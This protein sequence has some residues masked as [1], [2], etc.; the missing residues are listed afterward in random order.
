MYTACKIPS[1][2][3]STRTL[4]TL[5]KSDISYIGVDAS[6]SSSDE[7]LDEGPSSSM[8]PQRTVENQVRFNLIAV[9]H[10]LACLYASDSV[11]VF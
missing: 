5:N 3:L 6:L 1:L 9:N 4:S 7:Y 8:A 10:V 2:P 11:I